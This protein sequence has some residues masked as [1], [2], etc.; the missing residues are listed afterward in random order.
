M[1][2]WVAQKRRQVAALHTKVGI[3]TGLALLI[4]SFQLT[5]FGQERTQPLACRVFNISP[6]S[7]TLEVACTASGLAGPKV[8]MRFVDS[9]AGVERLS[10]RIFKPRVRDSAGSP[11]QLEI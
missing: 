3:L 1:P 2:Q 8:E 5:A 10:E 6:S 7:R 11:L 9:F 4:L